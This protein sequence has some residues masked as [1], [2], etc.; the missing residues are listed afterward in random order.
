[1]YFALPIVI[2]SPVSINISMG[3][4][5]EQGVLP[6]ACVALGHKLGQSDRQEG[7]A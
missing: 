3:A 5:R 7:G 4:M 1:M 6:V 2:A